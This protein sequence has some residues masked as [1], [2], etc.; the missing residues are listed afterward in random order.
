MSA[1]SFHHLVEK[2]I[3][4]KG[5]LLDF[6]DF[7]DCVNDC[8]ISIEMKGEDFFYFESK[9]GS[10]K[11]ISPPLLNQVREVQ[12]QKGSS[13]MYWKESFYAETYNESEFLK[14]KNR[15]DLTSS[16]QQKGAKGIDAAKKESILKKLLPLMSKEKGKFWRE[17]EEKHEEIE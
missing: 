6:N 5:K 7:V 17:L 8:G 13:K 9:K 2:R 16:A 12:F 10:S 14:K 11:K 3:R 1:D 15:R 4:S